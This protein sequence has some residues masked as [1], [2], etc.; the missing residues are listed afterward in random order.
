MLA[1]RDYFNFYKAYDGYEN[2][3]LPSY[4]FCRTDFSYVSLLTIFDFLKSKYLEYF[5]D[6]KKKRHWA[7]AGIYEGRYRCMC[8]FFSTFDFENL[9]SNS[10]VPIID[11]VTNLENGLLEIQN[12]SEMNFKDDLYYQGYYYLGYYFETMEL[13]EFLRKIAFH[14]YSLDCKDNVPDEK[15]RIEI[16][17][18]LMEQ[19]LIQIFGEEFVKN[20]NL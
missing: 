12:L 15:K 2:D 14:Y 17:Y 16:Q 10:F 13:V 18:T 8:K 11:Y 1:N 9:R 20:G 7:Y 19:S 4:K 6:N 5:K 3:L